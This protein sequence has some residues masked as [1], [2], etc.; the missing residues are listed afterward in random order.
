MRY[1][2]WRRS[3]HAAKPGRLVPYNVWL[4]AAHSLRLLQR[5]LGMALVLRRQRPKGCHDGNSYGLLHGPGR[6][7]H[8]RRVHQ[9]HSDLHFL[10]GLPRRH[11]PGY[12]HNL[13]GAK[14]EHS[15]KVCIGHPILRNNHSGRGC[16][17]SAPPVIDV[18]HLCQDRRHFD[19]V[20]KVNQLVLPAQS[21][22]LSE[23][24]ERHHHK[25][26]FGNR[27]KFQRL[28]CDLLR[29]EAVALNVR[30]KDGSEEDNSRLNQ[31]LVDL[32]RLNRIRQSKGTQT[33][34][35]EDETIRWRFSRKF[36]LLAV[37][38]NI[39]ADETVVP[40]KHL[41]DFYVRS[42]PACFLQR[43]K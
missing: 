40:P 20:G 11:L 28:H 6:N 30:A 19:F 10:P 13:V 7:F 5:K 27:L 35:T 22:N 23:F 17:S 31:N 15:N 16:C 14:P 32:R 25:C 2:W 9:R 29:K 38:W 43:P 8:R 36:G 24:L 1:M 37:H 3:S 42:C 18:P 26:R 4:L 39:H 41:V 34:P 12:R 21:R 33:R